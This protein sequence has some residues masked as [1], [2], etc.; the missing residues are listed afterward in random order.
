MTYA[1]KASM[2]AH[3]RI[4]F[5]L[6]PLSLL[7][8]QARDLS[9][10]VFDEV[11]HAD[12]QHTYARILR[13]FLLATPAG[14]KQLPGKFVA[15]DASIRTSCRLLGLTASPYQLLSKEAQGGERPCSL[16]DLMRGH[17]VTA[18]DM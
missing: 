18:P 13:N 1:R 8:M 11:H 4:H 16:E 12:A 9:L 14:H 2:L 5:N 15:S 17:I 3:L 7:C 6:M 10:V